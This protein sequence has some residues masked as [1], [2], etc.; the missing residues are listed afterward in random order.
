MSGTTL[1]QNLINALIKMFPAKT[2]N[3]IFLQNLVLLNKTYPTYIST[4]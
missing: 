1:F 4:I 2:L 3:I